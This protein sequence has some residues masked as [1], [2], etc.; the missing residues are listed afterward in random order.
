[1]AQCC[2]A[3]PDV[4][5]LPW[6]GQYCD[7]DA[8][9]FPFDGVTVRVHQYFP[10]VVHINTGDFVQWQAETGVT[11][12]MHPL[13]SDDGLWPTQGNTAATENE[14]SFSHRFTQ[15]GTFCFHCT[16]HGGPGECGAEG[17]SGEVIVTGEPVFVVSCHLSCVD[18]SFC[19]IAAPD[20]HTG[21]PPGVQPT[22]RPPFVA[23]P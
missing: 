21:I 8:D 9:P 7:D 16:I 1:M 4:F 5:C 17:M 13:A 15:P 10:P 12:E 22:G 11:F 2:P 14:T 19:G 6:H 23:E 18:A 20:D 3:R